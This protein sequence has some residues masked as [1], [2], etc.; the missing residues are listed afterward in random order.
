[1]EPH[2]ILWNI[3]E[4]HGTSQNSAEPLSPYEH[5]RECPQGLF[6]HDR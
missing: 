6:P 3:I 4:S 1:M 2:G 5:P